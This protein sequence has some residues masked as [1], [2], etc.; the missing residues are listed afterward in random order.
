MFLT[1]WGTWL[2]FHL[3]DTFLAKLWLLTRSLVKWAGKAPRQEFKFLS[4]AGKLHL[5]V[6]GQDTMEAVQ[7]EGRVAPRGL[8]GTLSL[9]SR[10]PSLGTGQRRKRNGE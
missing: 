3:G 2:E 10:N 6:C 4:I 7:S 1:I 5:P 9:D 8:Y